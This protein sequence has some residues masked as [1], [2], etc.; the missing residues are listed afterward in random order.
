MYSPEKLPQIFD[1]YNNNIINFVTLHEINMYAIYNPINTTLSQVVDRFYQNYECNLNK[2]Y[3]KIYSDEL[4]TFI[5]DLNINLPIIDLGLSKI[6]KFILKKYFDNKSIYDEVYC[7]NRLKELQ[8]EL[9]KEFCSMQIFFK[10]LSGKNI[11]LDVKDNFT[12]YD[13]KILLQDKINLT[14]DSQRFVFMG[15]QL[16]DNKTLLDYNLTAESWIHIVMNLRG[17][18]FHETS[19][20]N[21]NFGDL[22]S[23][24]FVVKPNILLK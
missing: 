18:M 8:K 19:G 3:I 14:P 20:R 4:K 12:I 2:V 16:Q 11:C 15:K 9:K 21:G 10:H 7:K 17:G 5:T 24:A 1:I 22:Q 13:V 6:T 23:I